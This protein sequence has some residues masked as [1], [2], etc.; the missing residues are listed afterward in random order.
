MAIKAAASEDPDL[1][2]IGDQMSKFWMREKAALRN[3]WKEKEGPRKLRSGNVISVA[4][5]SSKQQTVVHRRQLRHAF[6]ESK[7]DREHGQVQKKAKEQKDT[8]QDQQLNDDGQFNA[9]GTSVPSDS[10]SD[11]DHY[12]QGTASS[13]STLE[14]TGPLE[15]KSNIDGSGEPSS[16][17]RGDAL[18]IRGVNVSSRCM[19]LSPTS[20]DCFQDDEESEIVTLLLKADV[21]EV[22]EQDINLLAK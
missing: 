22:L 1:K 4:K 16:K 18:C 6:V 14:S 21:P 9:N 2:A 17:L 19:V 15:E 7:K 11:D 10:D 12:S 20:S 13:W 5:D 8:Q 3:F